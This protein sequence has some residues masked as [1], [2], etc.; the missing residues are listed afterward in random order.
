ML[1]VGQGCGLRD[2]G[3]DCGIRAWTEGQGCGLWDCPAS[4]G[5]MGRAR[6]LQNR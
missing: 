4:C 5:P 2:K 3:V 1:T 6:T